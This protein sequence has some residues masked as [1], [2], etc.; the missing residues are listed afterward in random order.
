VPYSIDYK[1]KCIYKKKSDGSRGE[2][3]GCT[4]GNIKDYIAAVQIHAESKTTK[5]KLK[6]KSLREM[7]DN[8]EQIKPIAGALSQIYAV[9]KPYSGCELTSLV[10]P[11]DPLLGIGAG[12]SIV[13]DEIH[14]VFADE[15]LANDIANDLFEKHM[16][17]ESALEEKKEATTKKVKSALDMLE[18]KRKEH[19]DMVKEDPK[20][21]SKHRDQIAVVTEKIDDLMTKLEKI[22]KSKKQIVKE[23]DKKKKTKK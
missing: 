1:N 16:K 17:A 12:H 18:S 4:K 20:N 3:V 19:M 10:K 11:I 22:E 6:K 21:A 8:P 23:D 9:Q 5:M 13:P 7:L 14:A 2:K 15:D